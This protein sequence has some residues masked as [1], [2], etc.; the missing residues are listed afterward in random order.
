MILKYS[1]VRYVPSVVRDE[2]INIGVVVETENPPGLY[3]QFLSA[4]S[5]VRRRYPDANVLALRHL[6]EHFQKLRREV[7]PHQSVFDFVK[8]PRVTLET[9]HRGSADTSLQVTAPRATIGSDP[10]A[11]LSELFNLFVAEAPPSPESDASTALAPARFRQLVT[12]RLR[13]SGL[14]D[15]DQLQPQF[16]VLGTVQPW[17]FDFGHRNAGLTLVQSLALRTTAD[18]AMNRALLLQGRV[19]DV[20]DAEHSRPLTIAVADEINREAPAVK[21]LDHHNVKIVAAEDTATLKSLLH[22]ELNLH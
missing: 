18:E 14:I 8:S 11:E 21:Y 22:P 4:M 7:D 20:A 9:L 3:L 19:E 12:T 2:A 1:V 13:R 10:A 15:R 17:V 6:S 16:Q 5:R